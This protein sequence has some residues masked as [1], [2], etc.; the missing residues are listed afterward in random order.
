[1]FVSVA[2]FPQDKE[3]FTVADP[4][5]VSAA[6]DTLASK[7]GW[8][9]TYEDPPY[10]YAADIEPVMRVPLGG[11]FGITYVISPATLEPNETE[12][13]QSTLEAARQSTG[14]VFE[15]RNSAHRIHI[16]PA[17]VRDA[18]G[19]LV[20]VI[21]VLDAHITLPDQN[22]N[23]LG[24]LVAICE[25]VSRMTGEHVIPGTT[26]LHFERI[27]TQIVAENRLA[28]EVLSSL[29]D[30]IAPNFSWSLYYD[31]GDHDYALNIDV[32]RRD[33]KTSNV[34]TGSK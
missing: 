19:K 11:R 16:V 29:L 1:V 33:T 15:M 22:Q 21:P 17:K 6:I 18:S 25:A 9:V 27:R 14:I 34:E 24:A 12:V 5:P 13:L 10:A 30:S 23:A 4:R 20:Q 3:T 26:P 7:Y 8:L 32:V 2:T 28:R 31:P